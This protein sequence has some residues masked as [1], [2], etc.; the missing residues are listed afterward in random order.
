[1]TTATWYT[2]SSGVGKSHACFQGF[3]PKTHYVKPLGPADLKWWDGYTGQ[4]TVIFN[5]FRGQLPFSELMDLI[6][7]W[8]KSVSRRG[9]EPV[10]F[11]ATKILISSIRHPR[12]VYVNQDGEPWEQFDS[13]CKVVTLEGA[14]RRIATY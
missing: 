3:D 14:N 2:G 4:E 5:E 6:D 8:P 11:L 7:K 12:D 10:P 13:R 1:M 9:R